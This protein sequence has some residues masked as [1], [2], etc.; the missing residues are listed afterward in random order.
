MLEL[1]E[2]LLLNIFKSWVSIAPASQCLGQA[3]AGS[4]R[5]QSSRSSCWGW[6]LTLGV[7]DLGAPRD[8]SIGD[9]S[10]AS[11]ATPAFSDKPRC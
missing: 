9:E 3:T 6:A 11:C 2:K 10:P 4:D 7:E 5:R 8:K 1:V